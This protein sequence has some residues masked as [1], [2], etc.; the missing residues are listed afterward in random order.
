M[1]RCVYVDQ[2]RLKDFVTQTMRGD[3][4]VVKCIVEVCQPRM[5]HALLGYHNDN[6]G[7]SSLSPACFRARKFMPP[8]IVS[9]I[10][11]TITADIDRMG[12]LRVSAYD[13]GPSK[14][15]VLCVFG[16]QLGVFVAIYL[17]WYSPL[18]YDVCPHGTS[19]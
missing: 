5:N 12:M 13:L 7:L 19:I 15:T 1:V 9:C 14:T 2:L 3:Q 17:Y 6:A 8:S 10:T 11:T 16:L 18:L 4:A